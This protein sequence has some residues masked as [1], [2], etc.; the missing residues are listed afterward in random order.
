MHALHTSAPST[1]TVLHDNSLRAPDSAHV[2]MF[3]GFPVAVRVRP[4]L[5]E[6]SLLIWPS[7]AAWELSCKLCAIMLRL[8]WHLLELSDLTNRPETMG[9]SVQRFNSD[10]FGDQVEQI[11]L[12]LS[13]TTLPY[14][15]LLQPMLMF[16]MLCS[17]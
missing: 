5:N 8:L 12:T 15:V 4:E 1:C 16:C 17:T 14:D 7:A 3:C 2:V 10:M 6:V 11:W 9:R 13:A